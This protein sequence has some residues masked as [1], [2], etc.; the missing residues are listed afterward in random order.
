VFFTDF[1]VVSLAFGSGVLEGNVFA[2]LSQW[3]GFPFYFLD[4]FGI[5]ES[6]RS[7]SNTSDFVFYEKQPVGNVRYVVKGLQETNL[8]KNI[9]KG[10]VP[11]VSCRLVTLILRWAPNVASTASVVEHE[12]GK[13]QSGQQLGQVEPGDG[14]V[15][16]GPGGQRVDLIKRMDPDFEVLISYRNKYNT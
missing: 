6:P 14:M 10:T 13:L 3:K 2:R 7:L 1:T 12:R 8:T 4:T 5:K 11:G 9:C 15:L 16:R